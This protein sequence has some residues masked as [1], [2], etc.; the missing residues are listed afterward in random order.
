MDAARPL[1]PDEL[2]EHA[3]F[4][5]NLARR[6]LRDEHL[7]ED[8]AQ[9]TLVAALTHPPRERGA[10]QAWLARTARNLALNRR[11]AA[12]R[13]ERHEQAASRPEPVD[14]E[15]QALERLELQ[16]T[17]FTQV[18]ALDEAKRAAL[19]LRYHEGL[20]PAEIAARLGVP[21]KTVK[22][23]LARGL[24]ELRGRLER[25]FGAED[26]VDRRAYALALATL[27]RGPGLV[28][29]TATL[30]AGGLVMKTMLVVAA[31]GLAWLAWTETRTAPET[32]EE[33]ARRQEPVVPAL[34][35]ET[36]APAPAERVAQL[37]AAPVPAPMPSDASYVLTGT[38]RR[39]GDGAALA[40]VAIE[41]ILFAPRME[42][43]T[44]TTGAGGRYRIE[45]N[46]PATVTSVSAK[47]TATTTASEQTVGKRPRLG[48]ELVAD[49]WVTAGARLF[50]RVVDERGDPV[51][52]ARV[53]AWCTDRFDPARPEDR[54]AISAAD[55]SFTLEHL[56]EEFVLYAEKPGLACRHGLRGRL[57]PGVDVADLEVVMGAAA[58]LRGHVV[59]ERG[60]PIAGAELLSQ[61]HMGTSERDVTSVLG[62]QRFDAHE[63]RA[64]SDASGRF[65]LGPVARQTWNAR[66]NHPDFLETFASLDP[67]IQDNVVEM[68]A[69]NALTGLVRD[70]GGRPIA[71]AEVSARTSQGGERRAST[72]ADGRFVVTPLATGDDGFVFVSA[73][74]YALF[75]LQSVA[76][77][78]TAPRFVEL[79]L[80]PETPLSGRVVDAE[81]QPIA[82]ALVRAEGEREL[83][84]TD[85]D[86]GERPTWEWKAG[87][88]E[89]RADAAG[90]FRFARL[91]P[92][93]FKL[94]ASPPDAPELVAEQRV[95]SGR[96]DVELRIDR[97][98]LERVVFA[99]TVRDARTREPLP[100]FRVTLRHAETDGSWRGRSHDFES[101]PESEAA[102]R[103]RLAGHAPGRYEV[104]VTAP[105]YAG[106][107]APKAELGEGEQ[108]FDA[109]LWPACAPT[110]RV[111][112]ERGRP[113]GAR[114]E[115][116]DLEGRI[117][118][119]DYGTFTQNS[120]DVAGAEG[121]LVPGLPT[122]VVRVTASA[123]G[124]E[125][126]TIDVDLSVPPLEAIEL[127]LPGDP[128]ARPVPLSLA[129]LETS[130]PELEGVGDEE[131]LREAYLA[132]RVQPLARAAELEF[133]DAEGRL[134]ARTRLEPA[135]GTMFRATTTLGDE[136][137]AET[138]E[139][140]Q[141]RLDLPL[142]ATLAVLRAPGCVEHRLELALD[143]GRGAHLLC[144]LLL[145][146]R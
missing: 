50:A 40:G 11:T 128:L 106:W 42:R 80:E 25:R 97:A 115:F 15:G 120:V 102:G 78:P 30:L 124:L 138:S 45:C 16:R 51:A 122:C 88:D 26:G 23:R 89:V 141:M 22:T 98:A 39:R 8:V 92:G 110:F 136:S 4:L 133:L 6:L 31:S 2:F 143:P 107:N 68:C 116:H 112:D 130:V 54:G 101:E 67:E 96:E 100:A 28:T 99:G 111:V 146:A 36:S 58:W 56:G 108:R 82:D 135:G 29:A 75:A 109:R 76:V 37:P 121:A 79:V 61:P 21:V 70:A 86:F 64:T 48:Q 35:V 59:D 27:A 72:G 32:R 44:T 126:R 142:R 127:V 53:R 131:R 24:E 129:L 69:G 41:A 5:K 90:F 18:L 33:L 125:E 57:T 119:V 38:V 13:R 49:V 66:V 60:R 46:A 104:R 145:E 47:A 144:V 140:P 10:L 139:G 81:G 85:V 134:V 87:L 7:A 17:V 14:A 73:E 3:E 113:V 84:Y 74:G 63:V 132:G 137:R 95:R 77:G 71:G 114:L 83:V 91:Y 19:F 117:L 1:E 105:G 43:V 9:E 34:P 20:E 94:F 103:F 62:V 93:E 55:G 52:G 65:E 123:H 12:A 118:L